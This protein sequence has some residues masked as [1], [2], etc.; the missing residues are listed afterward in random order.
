MEVAANTIGVDIDADGLDRMRADGYSNLVVA[1][2]AKEIDRAKLVPIATA[3]GGLDWI[4]CGEVIEHV[5]DQLSLV[6][7]LLVLSQATGASIVLTTP[8]PFYWGRF[9]AAARR[10]E[11]VHPDHTAYISAGVL[12]SLVRR[13]GQVEY[14]TIDFYTNPSP[15]LFTRIAKNA[16]AGAFPCVADGIIA[17]WKATTQR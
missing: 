4:V 3:Q 11:T 2:I 17:R 7:G 14:L 13:A 16:I 1:D 10:R 15:S 6:R 8:N 12:E 9:A 5:F